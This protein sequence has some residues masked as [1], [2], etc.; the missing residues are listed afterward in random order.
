MP[1]E[2]LPDFRL[3]GRIPRRTFLEAA[4]LAAAATAL[5]TP[6]RAT[7]I[8][9]VSD[10]TWT[11]GPLLPRPVKGQAQ[12]V[13]DGRIVYSCGYAFDTK[14]YIRPSP[15]APRDE[16][17]RARSPRTIRYCRETWLFDPQSQKFEQLPDAPVGVF[18]PE[19]LAVGDDFYL[20]TGAMR[21]PVGKLVPRD[22]QRGEKRDLTSPRIFRLR[23]ESAGW[24]WTELPPM[25]FGRFLPG[26]AAVG[27]TLYVIGGQSS[28]GSAAVTGDVAGTHINAVESL[29]LAK[30][31]SGWRDVPPVPGMARENVAVAAAGGKIY[32]FGGFYHPIHHKT[33]ISRLY[34]KAYVYD[35]QTIRW[36]QL[37]DMPFAIEGS[38]AATLNDREILI[39]AG[40]RGGGS[41]SDTPFHSDPRTR[42]N[43]ET[44]VYDTRTERYRLL[45]SKLPPAPDDPVQPQ[46]STDPTSQLKNY[47]ILPRAGLVGDTVYLLGSEVLDLAYSN[48]SDKM[49]IG[50]LR[51]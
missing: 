15:S 38:P 47:W 14:G 18:W 29:D 19:G 48:C 23:K 13:I 26:V 25:R 45:P 22:W 35:P 32:A 27:S 31:E 9:S 7:A 39:F 34:G 44:I 6:A 42:A 36:D 10:I 50:K 40:V 12:G 43:L 37:S 2:F 21:N 5:S 49:W 3:T 24:S 46:N 16:V 1:H 41:D 20:L 4:G 11:P 51:G 28:F 8:S 30:P 33:R 17:D